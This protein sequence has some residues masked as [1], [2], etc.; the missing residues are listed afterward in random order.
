VKFTDSNILRYY[1]VNVQNIRPG[2][3]ITVAEFDKLSPVRFSSE[4]QAP[5][6]DS[7]WAANTSN[8]SKNVT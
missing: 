8:K 5:F 2:P 1:V 3:S 6:A 7:A 4:E